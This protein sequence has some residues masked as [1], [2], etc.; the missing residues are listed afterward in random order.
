ME[1]A[2]IL[3]KQMSDGTITSHKNEKN[4][5]EGFLKKWGKG[6]RQV[7]TVAKKL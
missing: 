5:A 4:M 6:S 3:W 1:A 7:S 2:Q